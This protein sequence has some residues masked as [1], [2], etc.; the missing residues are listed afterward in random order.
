[1]N[2]QDFSNRIAN[3]DYDKLQQ[4]ALICRGDILTMTTLA[5]FYVYY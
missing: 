3:I 1:M 5:W 4:E 2:F